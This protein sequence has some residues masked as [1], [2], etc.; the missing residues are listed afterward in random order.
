MR[1]SSRA[2][3]LALLVPLHVPYA[4]TDAVAFG[5]EAYLSAFN[6]AVAPILQ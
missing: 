2:R 5:T 3:T 4:L 1:A 6:A